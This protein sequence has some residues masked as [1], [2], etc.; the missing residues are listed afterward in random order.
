MGGPIQVVEETCSE[1]ILNLC[2]VRFF[3]A[4][5]GSELAFFGARCLVNVFWV[6]FSY[7]LA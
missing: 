1:K 5:S 6:F 7:V 4:I 3:G 2:Q